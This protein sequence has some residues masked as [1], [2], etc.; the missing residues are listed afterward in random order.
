MKTWE[1]VFLKVKEYV[2]KV[3]DKVKQIIGYERLKKA[4]KKMENILNKLKKPL[5]SVGKA[6]RKLTRGVS[7]AVRR[8]ARGVSR[9]VRRAAR[10]VKRTIR[11]VK[12]KL[13]RVAR[14]RF[15]APRMRVRFRNMFFFS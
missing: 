6:A 15:R 5:K 12:N 11:S 3:E 2:K 7:R 8:V 1:A 9:A 13:R 4:W 10:S 14:V